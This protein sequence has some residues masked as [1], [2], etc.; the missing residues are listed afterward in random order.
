M[1]LLVSDFYNGE[2]T[3]SVDAFGIERLHD[4]TGALDGRIGPL[5]IASMGN[6]A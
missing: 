1:S 6:A 2:R 3:I 5:S 4:R